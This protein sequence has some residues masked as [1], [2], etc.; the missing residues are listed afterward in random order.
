MEY[1][2]STDSFACPHLSELKLLVTQL[3]LVPHTQG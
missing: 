3:L 2:K 1:D